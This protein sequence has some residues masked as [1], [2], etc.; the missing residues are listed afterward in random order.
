MNFTN[1]MRILKGDVVGHSFHGNQWVTESGSF[2]AKPPR[3]PKVETPAPQPVSS[4]P[5]EESRSLIE[6]AVSR[7]SPESLIKEPEGKLVTPA[8]GEKFV[9][10][11]DNKIALREDD[12]KIRLGGALN[13]GFVPVTM[14]DGS[15]AAIKLMSSPTE[16]GWQGT[17]EYSAQSEVLAGLVAKTLNLPIRCC[18]P[19]AGQPNAVLQ[20]WLEGET[21]EEKGIEDIERCTPE[22]QAQARQIEFFD[23]LTGNPDRFY[24]DGELRNSANVFVQKDST[25]GGENLIGIDNALSFCYAKDLADEGGRIP[26]FD[27]LGKD[28]TKDDLDGM[29]KQIS[30]LQP[31]FE[32]LNRMDSYNEMIERFRTGAVTY[33]S[34]H[35]I[36]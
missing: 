14:A 8:G 5:A 31:N 36:S 17:A 30:D 4:I 32:A 27:F 24:L 20:P 25:N 19:V 11:K 34:N 28:L 23:Q 26:N 2:I 22:Q 9:A 15:K 1:I 7:V 16:C 18:E 3:A 29:Y 6:Q 10:L 33:M 13:D 21:L 12:K 35:G